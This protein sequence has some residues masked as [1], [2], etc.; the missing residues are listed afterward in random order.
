MPKSGRYVAVVPDNAES[1]VQEIRRP[2]LCKRQNIVHTEHH[3]NGKIKRL[4]ECE[5]SWSALSARMTPASAVKYTTKVTSRAV[6]IMT[7]NLSRRASLV[8]F[9]STRP[10]EIVSP[11]K[12][13]TQLEKRRRSRS[14]RASCEINAMSGTA[15]KRDCDS[16][17]VV[18]RPMM[19][20]PVIHVDNC[21]AIHA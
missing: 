3:R 16:V 2:R 21:L 18:V 1:G 10:A 19:A 20:A 15:A 6:V 14:D 17:C 4:S 13:K 7:A 9:A 5:L 8:A 11:N 12:T